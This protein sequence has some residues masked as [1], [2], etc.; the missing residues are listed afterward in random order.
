MTREEY[1]Q[2]VKNDDIFTGG[3]SVGGMSGN[4]LPPPVP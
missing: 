1:I 3:E 2:K 4:T